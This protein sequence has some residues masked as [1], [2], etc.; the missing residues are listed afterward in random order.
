MKA[1]C[2]ECDK[3][4]VWINMS[5]SREENLFYCDYHVPRGCTCNL[6]DIDFD[7]IPEKGQ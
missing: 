5:A 6:C 1:K 3:I 2:C 7:G 4:A